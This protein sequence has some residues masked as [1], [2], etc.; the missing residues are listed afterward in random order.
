MITIL[1]PDFIF[2]DERGTLV[3]LVHEGYKQI[4]V[5]SSKAGT[6]RGNHC[7][8]LNREGFY[9][10][11]GSFTV[12]VH[13]G[14]EKASFTFGKGDMFVIEP[15]VM[16]SFVYHENSTLI[17]FYDKGVELPDGTKDIIPEVTD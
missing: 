6:V 5:V 12:D 10:I 15:E 8:N 14:D 13:K 17:G 1:T 2:E 4:N 3:Q 16:H 7:H 9:V 11:E